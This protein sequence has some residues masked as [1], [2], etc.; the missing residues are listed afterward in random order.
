MELWENCEL[1]IW[2]VFW[3]AKSGN[4]THKKVIGLIERF[5]VIITTVWNIKT[6]ITVYGTILMI[7]FYV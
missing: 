3:G 6:A 5:K 1:K 7:L 4:H 2:G